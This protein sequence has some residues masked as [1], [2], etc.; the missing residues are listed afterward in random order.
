MPEWKITKYDPKNKS[1]TMTSPNGETTVA[2]I[3]DS[4]AQ[5]EQRKSYIVA[6]QTAHTAIHNTFKRKLK[7]K[8]YIW[9]LVVLQALYII[10]SL[11]GK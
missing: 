4:H 2:V 9:V 3:P 7:N 11:R 6:H 5:L 1:V 8:N 10:W